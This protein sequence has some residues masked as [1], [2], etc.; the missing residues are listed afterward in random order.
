MPKSNLA[1]KIHPSDLDLLHADVRD[2]HACLAT[3]AGPRGFALV[4]IMG[5]KGMRPDGDHLVAPVPT[6]RL[7]VPDRGQT[8][9]TA[10]ADRD[11]EAGLRAIEETARP[12]LFEPEIV[13]LA[14]MLR[15]IRDAAKML[16]P[17]VP[18]VAVRLTEEGRPSLRAWAS[19]LTLG[20]LEA[21]V[22]K[23]VA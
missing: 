19:C 8:E 22:L 14:T 3:F 12:H 11:F 15:V 23:A 4:E 1:E 20:D 7:W 10:V 18:Q 17:R 16:R 6:L 13:S 5:P 2:G 21:A 9:V